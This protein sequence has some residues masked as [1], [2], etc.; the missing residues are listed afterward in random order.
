M[1]CNAKI[2]E[3]VE[4]IEEEETVLEMG[5]VLINKILKK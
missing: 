1:V 2:K 4:E 3:K 5:I